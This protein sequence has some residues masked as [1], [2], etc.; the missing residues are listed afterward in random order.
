MKHKPIGPLRLRLLVTLLALPF[1]L[2]LLLAQQ[3][4]PGTGPWDRD[5]ILRTGTDGTT[6]GPEALFEKASGVPSL[7]RDK[8]GRLL[9]AFQWFPSRESPDWDR[10]AVKI[11]LDGGATWSTPQAITVAALPDGY[12]RPFDPTLAVLDDGRIRIYFSSSPN[13][14][15]IPDASVGTYSAISND[16]IH[17]TFEPGRRFGVPG[18]A[19][20]D[21]A[22]LRLGDTWHFTSPIAGR[23]DAA[24]HAVSS[25]GLNFTRVADITSA[26]GLNW[27][28]NLVPYQ[29]GMRFYGNSSHGLWWAFSKDGS[30]WTPPT[31]LSFG[32]GDPAVV[33]TG[34]GRFHIVYVGQPSGSTSDRTLYVPLISQNAALQ[35]GLALV[36]PA[37]E[38]VPLAL[39]AY[40]NDGKPL[41]GANIINPSTRVLGAQ[42]QA[43]G[44]VSEFFG[45]GLQISNGWARI[46]GALRDTAGFFLV[47]NPDLTTLYGASM[48]DLLMANFI[49][50]EARDAEVSLVN[51]GNQP[52]I[53]NI[54]LIDD[55]GLQAGSGSLSIPP[56]GRWEQPTLAF[57]AS[58]RIREGGYL[59]VSS[60]AP[61]SALEV[62]GG[63]GLPRSSLAFLELTGSPSLV[64]PQYVVGGGWSTAVTVVNLENQNT[65]VTVSLIGDD[66]VLLGNR[67]TLAMP[68]RGRLVMADPSALVSGSGGLIQGYLRISSTA[69]RIT[70]YVRFGDAR[71]TDFQTCLPLLSQG[72]TETLFPHVASDATYFTGLAVLNGNA[73]PATATISVHDRTGQ[74]IAA[75][76]L[77]MAANSR[78]ARLLT[79]LFP[80]L[81]AMTSGYFR[82]QTSRPTPAY[83]LFGTHSL[84]AICAIA[85][86]GVSAPSASLRS[87]SP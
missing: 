57:L 22:V 65:T 69:T 8:Q 20:V 40:G 83:A 79:E 70:G 85:P 5:L 16:G 76:T 49:L 24:Y 6:F 82:V 34:D 18:T 9:A 81:P 33:A 71:R 23:Q 66:G 7:V 50:P 86:L 36:N 1:A 46:T 2:P 58:D 37:S 74:Q 61:L 41:S 25:D 60:T 28:G 84:S 13:A 30:T 39:S 67:A 68:P 43:A 38:T 3:P 56:H 27:L 17:F 87:Q 12:Q 64:A 47:F 78:F 19:V 75:R 26:D 52:A 14:T 11:Y 51:P 55:R 63:N 48:S 35:T 54:Q 62:F 29:D 21:P 73:E 44:L 4:T 77:E 31:F 15:P 10:V 72:R 32:G 42:T 53:V 80:A 45:A 59:Q